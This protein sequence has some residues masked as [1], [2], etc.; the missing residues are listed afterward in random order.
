MPKILLFI[1]GETSFLEFISQPWHWSVSG[2]MIALILF[3]LV[4]MGKSFGVSSSFKALCTLAGAGKKVPY[5]DY[6]I[7]SEYWRLSFVVGAAIG[8]YIAAHFLQSP[9]AVDISTSTIEYLSTLGISYP[10]S[11]ASGQ[12]FLPTDVFNFASIK[13]VIL[14]LAGGVLIGFGT[15]Y[16]NGCTSG[17]AITGLAHFQLP[18]LITVMGF[19]IGGLIM[20][21]LL[22]PFLIAS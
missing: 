12:G 9:Q 21:H 20:T 13:G 4:G 11:D 18:S 6:K 16:G 3:L 14:A 15:R 2:L 10:A 1:T 8:G 5:F 22:L 19:F 17:H 7:E